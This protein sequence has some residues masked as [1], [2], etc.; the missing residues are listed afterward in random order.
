M[1]FT[2]NKGRS[3]SQVLGDDQQVLIQLTNKADTL[4]A[5]SKDAADYYRLLSEVGDERIFIFAGRSFY[6]NKWPKFGPV[7]FI[8]QF[9]PFEAL[10]TKLAH[11]DSMQPAEP[12]FYD[13]LKAVL[14]ESDD[15]TRHLLLLV[16]GINAAVQVY[17][18]K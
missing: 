6:V 16:I 12:T 10:A 14:S 2:I 9:M 13:T 3:L 8:E 11:Y 7:D 17:G 1:S 15:V 18:G 5:E 4:L